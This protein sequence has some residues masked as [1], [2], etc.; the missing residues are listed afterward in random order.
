MKSA[1]PS[2]SVLLTPVTS[3]SVCEPEIRIRVTSNKLQAFLT[4]YFPDNCRRPTLAD[5]YQRLEADG[6]CFGLDETALTHALQRPGVDFLFARGIPPQSG[7]NASIHYAF[8]LE[9]RGRPAELEDGRVDFK[10]LNLFTVVRANDV[11]ARK[12][13]PTPGIP[14]MDVYGDPIPPL[15]GKW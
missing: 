8:C 11:L 12:K 7:E 14:G 9:N 5:L 3:P 13:P 15:P 10:C 4:V 2:P 6:V 1:N